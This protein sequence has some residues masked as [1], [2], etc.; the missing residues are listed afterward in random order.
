[1]SDLL[2]RDRKAIWHPFTQHA[3]DGDPL[4][5]VRAQGARLVLADGREL[6]DGI[7]SWW[8]VLHGH[9]EP[10]LVAAA[11]AQFQQLDHVLFAGA[12]HEP[13]VALAERLVAKAP[14]GAARVF[15]SDNGST[16]VEVALKLVLQRWVHLGQPQRRVFLALAGG[17]HGDTFGAMA[18]GDPDP[19]FQPF[20]PLLFEVRRVPVAAAAVARAC[21]ELG[22][23]AAGMIL[24]PRLMG[25][26]GM[27]VQPEGFLAAV[28]AVTKQFGLPLIADEVLTG[29]GRTG[30][31]FACEHEGIEPDLLCLAKGLTGGMFPLAA[32]LVRDDY[33]AD[34]WSHDRARAFFHGHTFT[35]HPV[36]CAVALASMDLLAQ[37]NTPERFATLGREL[38][39]LLQS[40]P[41]L[42]RVANLRCCGGV[43]AFDCHDAGKVPFLARRRA[44]EAAGALLRP[45]GSTVYAMP[46]ACADTADLRTIA[47]AMAMMADC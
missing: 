47:T 45:L 11:H 15:Y 33:F 18:V 26:C 32:T 29:F 30:R 44:A 19:F 2:A 20:V 39:A 31:M 3:V 41:Q 17:Y 28:R 36:G 14:M 34:F 7:S 4:P 37:R 25:A 35:A 42:A 1:M 13:A 43:V 22:D 24:E 27:R 38:L 46:P 8:A 12:T 5:V 16:A 6:V 9:A 21:A 10:S 40:Q 23:R